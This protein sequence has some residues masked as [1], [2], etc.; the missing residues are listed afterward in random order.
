MRVYILRLV[1]KWSTLSFQGK[2]ETHLQKTQTERI[3]NTQI[4]NK[5]DKKLSIKINNAASSSS[6]VETEM[7][8]LSMLV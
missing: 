2:Y 3:A 6:P 8:Y 7:R 4:I 1:E 5:S